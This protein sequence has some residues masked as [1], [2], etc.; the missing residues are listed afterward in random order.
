MTDLK[1]F[2][3]TD[4]DKSRHIEHGVVAIAFDKDGEIY[5]CCHNWESAQTVANE[6]YRMLAIAND[7]AMEKAEIQRICNYEL[8]VALDC[9]GEDYQK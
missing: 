1:E 5:D 6:G 8:T 4:Q 2:Q 9:F 3:L 7:G